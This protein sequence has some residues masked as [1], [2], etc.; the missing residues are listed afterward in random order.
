MKYAL[1]TSAY[2]KPAASRQRRLTNIFSLSVGTLLAFLLFPPTTSLAGGH[3]DFSL[4]AGYRVDNLN[5]N[6]SGGSGGPNILSE[7]TWRDLRSYQVR[8]D[9][10]GTSDVGVYVRGSAS[11][12]WVQGGENQDSD[13][14]G[15]NRSLEFS[16]SINGVDGSRLM[17][18]Q[19]GIGYLFKLGEGGQV[20]VSPLIGYAYHTQNLRMT[21]GRQ[22]VSNLIYAQILDPSIGL[23]PLGPFSGLHS[24]YDATWYGPWLGA[25]V[26]WNLENRGRFKLRLE[27]HR[28]SYSATGNWNLRDD[29]KHPESFNQT[30]NG[31]GWVLELG[32]QELPSRRDWQWG[33]DLMLQRWHTG[34]G[35]DTTYLTYYYDSSSNKVTCDPYCVAKTRL[36]EVNWSS[37]SL[38]I[39][40]NRALDF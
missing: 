22:V 5:W 31:Q 39:T 38:N 27:A 3:T 4:M 20:H 11:Y 6:I 40:I 9:V 34:A 15:N 37:N 1:P 2:V 25:D 26:L 10:T 21:D 19:G 17:D 8:G 35:T 36:N 16:R 7:L 13:Y 23:P 14:A 18:Y 30:A 33:V 12:G 32:W 24:S 28:P 29:L